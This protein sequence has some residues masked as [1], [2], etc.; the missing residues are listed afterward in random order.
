MRWTMKRQKK[1]FSVS[2]H[3]M[4]STTSSPRKLKRLKKAAIG[5]STGTTSK[6]TKPTF[7]SNKGQKYV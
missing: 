1:G 3:S 6:N 4:I 7:K 5:M 2:T